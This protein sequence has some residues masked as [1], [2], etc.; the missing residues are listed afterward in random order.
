NQSL[1]SFF[2]ECIKAPSTDLLCGENIRTLVLDLMDARI[3]AAV[4]GSHKKYIFIIAGVSHIDNA[5]GWLQKGFK[6]LVDTCSIS[7]PKIK[8]WELA[9]RIKE[10][11]DC[12]EMIPAVD[13]KRFKSTVLNLLDQPEN[14]VQ[15]EKDSRVW[16]AENSETSPL[17][18]PAISSRQ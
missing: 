7:T 16:L 15:E 8:E 9:G 5:I 10:G 3:L 18:S 4:C 6:T 17:S 12:S 11:I 13:V 2:K 14:F 1:F